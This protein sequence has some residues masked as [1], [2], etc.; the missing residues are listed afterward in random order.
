MK[1]GIHHR[2]GSF[3]D[4]WVEYLKMSNIP[5]HIYNAFDN[6][7]IFKLKEDNI[8][9]FMWHFN[10]NFSEDMLHARTLLRS[11]SQINIRT[12]PD[13]NS[14][15]HFDDKIAQKYLLES[16]DAPFVKT[17]VFYT[18]KDAINFTNRCKFPIVFK[19]RGGAGSINVRLVRNKLQARRLINKA[20]CTG[21]QSLNRNA[22]FFDTIERFARQR[23]FHNF[24]RILKWGWKG[25]FVD[26]QFRLF[27]KQKGY[28]YFQEY[29]P[30]LKYDIRL[31]IIGE[32]CFYLKRYTRNNDFRASGSGILSFLP[33]DNFNKIVVQIAFDIAKKI[34]MQCVAFDFVFDEKNNPLIV[35]ISYGFQPYVY[36]QC[37]GYYDQNLIWME[38][39]VNLEFEIIKTFLNKSQ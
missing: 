27:S 16:I 2:I 15:W 11:L 35:E 14:Y 1:V 18:K 5:F 39:D 34:K 3:S 17:N 30:D 29:I 22:V 25:I 8:T 33:E 9:H 24:L 6:D 20:F 38:T 37:K 31:I 10:Q 21:F 7:I 28:I 26:K 23:N 4:R 12:F 32:K 36:D 13:E 19:L